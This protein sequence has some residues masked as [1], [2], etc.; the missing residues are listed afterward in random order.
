MKKHRQNQDFSQL[1]GWSM[2]GKGNLLK[3]VAEAKPKQS[4]LGMP[5]LIPQ[6]TLP[7]LV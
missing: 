2:L 7:V 3:A 1:L 6:P 4:Y 5:E